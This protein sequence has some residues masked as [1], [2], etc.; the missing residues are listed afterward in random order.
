MGDHYFVP[1]ALSISHK[2]IDSE[3]AG[4]VEIL[5][6]ARRALQSNL[7]DG[8]QL[9]GKLLSDLHKALQNHFRHEEQAMADLKYPDLIQHKISHAN[10]MARLNAIL[11][12]A[13]SCTTKVTL[14]LLDELFDI[15]IA[16]I[17][18]ADSGFK[19]FLGAKDI[20]P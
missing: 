1:P 7:D 3:H 5:N 2:G 11:H 9:A 18:R 10:C 13:T 6:A 12:E 8:N 16:D 19:S 17:I 14:T 20:F 15:I 4:L